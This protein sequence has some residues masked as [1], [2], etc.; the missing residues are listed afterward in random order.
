MK[1]SK[2]IKRM[3]YM[4][5]YMRKRRADPEYR[6]RQL[7]FTAAWKATERGQ[8]IERDRWLKKYGITSQDYLDLLN[9]QDGKCAICRIASPGGKCK[10]FAV[11]HC[12]QS[13]RIRGLLCRNCNCAIGLLGDDPELVHAALEYLQAL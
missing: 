11:D 3:K 1:E 9:E 8:Q 6:E 13:G 5:E 2:K 4:R 7:A 10:N 12:H